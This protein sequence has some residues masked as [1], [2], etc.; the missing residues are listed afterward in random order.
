MNLFSS[1]LTAVAGAI[2]ARYE[3]AQF[4]T[5]R[6]AVAGY[7]QDARFDADSATQ[8]EMVRK[9][10]YFERNSGIYNRLC[11]LFEQYVVG[12]Q[13][14]TVVPASSDQEWNKRASDWFDGWSAMPDL[15]SRQSWSTIQSLAARTWFVDGEVFCL[16]TSG[17]P[18]EDSASYPRIQLVERHR[19]ES[20][21]A[22]AGN[23]RIIDGIQV[24][25]R[26]RP[27]SYY[28]RKEDGSYDPKPADKVIHLFEPSR[29]G[30]YRGLPF[31]YPVINDLHDLDDLQILAGQAA[32]K[33]AAIADVLETA[34][35]E[36][37]PVKL[38]R[39]KV[40]GTNQNS[41]GTETV[42]SRV[43]K[44]SQITGA[45]TLAIKTGEKLHRLDTTRPS[46]PE[47]EHWDYLTSKVCAGVGISKLLVFPWSMQGTVTRADLDVANAFF[48]SRS[49]VIS[50]TLVLDVWFYVM[51]W[52]IKNVRELSDP[53]ADWRTV[54]TR[55]P[56]SVNVDVGRNSNALIEEYK[57]GWRTLEEICAE[58]GADWRR[59]LRQ[60]AKERAAARDIEVEFDLKEGELI[61]AVL[62][63]LTAN[64]P[65]Q[66]PAPAV[67]A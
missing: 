57:A 11:D 61:A 21:M 19:V 14:I 5:S 60:R 53:P 33:Q 4:S 35:G 54:T 50:S 2:L 26:G 49:A 15:T 9:S 25:D 36:F 23:A 17:R 1:I 24:D 46:G 42:E 3:G 67:P 41:A 47:R 28:V 31:V 59:V 32:K 58:L 18:R 38:R 66:A 56:R 16:K 6:S 13:G 20:P 64:K 65:T 8:F 63:A 12:P 55:A 62:E 7:V 10:R 30:Q 44:Y 40:E 52:A 29:V 51:D 43:K 27:I 45:T 48:R 37:D 39:E 34:A 22:L